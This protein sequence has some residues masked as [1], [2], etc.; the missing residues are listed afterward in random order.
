MLAEFDQIDPKM[1]TLEHLALHNVKH[2]SFNDFGLTIEF[3]NT[4]PAAESVAATNQQLVAVPLP[5]A[6]ADA[7]VYEPEPELSELE[8]TYKSLNL[9]T[10]PMKR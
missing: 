8:R 1:S 7:A 9:T 10:Y 3:Q 6:P 5:V 2:F 4:K